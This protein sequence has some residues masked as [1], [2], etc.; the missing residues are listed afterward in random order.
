MKS[1]REHSHQGELDQGSH[2]WSLRVACDANELNG[3]AIYRPD[4]SRYR[5]VLTENLHGS[6]TK[7][8]YICEAV[9]SAIVKTLPKRAGGLSTIPSP[10]SVE[11][12]TNCSLAVH[13]AS[14][15]SRKRLALEERGLHYNGD[16]RESRSIE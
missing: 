10:R 11:S 7:G 6:P 4:F 1:I 3:S 12:L 2:T 14:G 15:H 8:W 16:D 5:P 13:V 9:V